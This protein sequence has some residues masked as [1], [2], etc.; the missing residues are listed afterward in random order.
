MWET[1]QSPHKEDSVLFFLLLLFLRQIKRPYEE[2]RH[3]VTLDRCGGAVN[4]GTA[5]AGD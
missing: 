3:R 5:A 4:P 2:H 1:K